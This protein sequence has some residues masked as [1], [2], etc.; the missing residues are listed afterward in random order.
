MTQATLQPQWEKF[1]QD[2]LNCFGPGLRRKL[3]DDATE[4][5]LTT[6]AGLIIG[7]TPAVRYERPRVNRVVQRIIR[8]LTWYYHRACLS[9]DLNFLIRSHAELGARGDVPRL[10]RR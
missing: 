2:R 6:P 5:E 10:P 3:I 4:V 8:G 7:K 1:W 9:N